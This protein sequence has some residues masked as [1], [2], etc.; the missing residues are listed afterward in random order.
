MLLS[1]S[2]IKIEIQKI[3]SYYGQLYPKNRDDI[4]DIVQN[5]L[6]AALRLGLRE[7]SHTYLKQS[8]HNRIIDLNRLHSASKEHVSLDD[9]TGKNPELY[10]WKR[11]LE[12]IL[13]VKPSSEVNFDVRRAINASHRSGA[14]VMRLYFIEGMTC[15]EIAEKTGGTK[16]AVEGKLNRQIRRARKLLGDYS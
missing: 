10:G 2:G 15:K 8:I 14:N 7:L 16:S 12:E 11:C 13:S 9:G 4:E 6:C 3:V 5:V 1:D